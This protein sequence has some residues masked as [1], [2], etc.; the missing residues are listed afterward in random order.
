M[1][2]TPE[3]VFPVLQKDQWWVRKATLALIHVKDPDLRDQSGW[4][5]DAEVWTPN[6]LPASQWSFYQGLGPPKEALLWFRSKLDI[7]R[8][9]E[10]YKTGTVYISAQNH[11]LFFIA[12]IHKEIWVLADWEV[13]TSDLQN[14]YVFQPAPV[15]PNEV[16]DTRLE[17]V[18]SEEHA[19]LEAKP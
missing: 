12:V 17:R 6:E 4:Y 3:E 15:D 5:F 13:S 14:S 19:P 1:P 9:V 18:L 10:A 8:P 11:Q 7:K 2:L 16:H